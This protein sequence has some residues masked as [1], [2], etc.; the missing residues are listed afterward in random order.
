LIKSLSRYDNREKGGGK[1]LRRGFTLFE[2]MISFALLTLIGGSVLVIY[3]G[4]FAGTRKADVHLEPLNSLEML[5][6]IF[7][8][9]VAKNPNLTVPKGAR[10]GDY[11]YQVDD[12]TLNQNPV[13]G[14]TSAIMLRRL[15]IHVF[16]YAPD[17]TGGEGER[18]YV[19]TFLV[20]E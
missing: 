12:T 18:E 2:I 8:E 16:F 6:E 9:R 14:S 10:Y 15:T 7:R 11:I 4:I 5:G 3:S 1:P 19:S 20:G 13:A 17:A